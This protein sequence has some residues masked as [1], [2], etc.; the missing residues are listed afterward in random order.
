[1]FVLLET[2]SLAI[3]CGPGGALAYASLSAKRT[4][5]SE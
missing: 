4:A 2:R 5:T 3:G 1:M